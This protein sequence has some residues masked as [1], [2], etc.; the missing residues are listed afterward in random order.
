MVSREGRGGVQREAE[1]D[2]GAALPRG[3]TLKME[4]VVKLEQCYFDGAS[5]RQRFFTECDRRLFL[6]CPA[7][8]EQSC[9]P[10]HLNNPSA[11]TI[12]NSGPTLVCL[13]NVYF[14]LLLPWRLYVWCSGETVLPSVCVL[15]SHL[16]WMPPCTP[17]GWANAP[18]GVGFTQGGSQHSFF[19]FCLH[20]NPTLW[21]LPWFYREKRSSLP[22]V[23]R[24]SWDCT[25]I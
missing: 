12:N 20:L 23:S 3:S 5:C 22:S 14:L 13:G 2:G 11:I 24:Q 4:P 7:S 16:L 19:I 1:V 25:E 18:T 15:P 17:S 8:L 10:R 9:A 21:C 6:L